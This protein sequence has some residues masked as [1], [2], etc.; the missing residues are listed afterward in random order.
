MIMQIA[1]ILLVLG[2]AYAWATR[3]FFNAL[4]HLVAVIVGGAVAFAVWEPLSLAIVNATE[5]SGWLWG[6]IHACAW[7]IGLIVPFAI[8]TIVVR[9]ILDKTIPANVQLV[10]AAD[11][12]GGGLCGLGAGIIC[13]GVLV[14]AIGATRFPAGFLGYKP[15]WYN[16]D[17]G[18]GL[19]SLKLTGGLWVPADKLTAAFYSSLSINAFGADESLATW[20]P[21]L[22]AAVYANRISSEDF[23]PVT[24][25]KRED[26]RLNGRYTVGDPAGG[27]PVEQ[28]LRFELQGQM[29]PMPYADT[30]GE[31]VGTGRLEGFI[32][33]FEAG[34]KDPG[35]RGA[36]QVVFSNGQA[37]LV[38]ERSDGS[39]FNV[40]P[41]AM[42]SQASSGDAVYGRWRFDAD[43]VVLASVGGASSVQLGLEFVVP[44]GAEPIGL[45]VKNARID[46][47]DG[48][49]EPVVYADIGSRNA[50]VRDGAI[51]RGDEPAPEFDDSRAIVIDPTTNS[52]V[53]PTNSLTGRLSMHVSM[54]RRNF[55]L[56]ED[57]RIQTGTGVYR[58][59]ADFNAPNDRN[60]KTDKFGVGRGQVLVQ[61]D[62]SDGS[63][64]SIIGPVARLEDADAP[65]RLI[66]TAGIAYDAVGYIYQESGEVTIRYTPED[67]L[68]GSGDIATPLSSTRT[69]QQLA[70][71]F[72][73]SFGVEIDR[74]AIGDTVILDF[75]PVLTLDRRQD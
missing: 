34:A 16:D 6:T 21:D 40:F 68:D 53:Q 15:I 73:C 23:T 56:D 24:S 47:R 10:T 19:G 44:Q 28:L 55:S 69:D 11:Y 61:I 54:A 37:R 36:G 18:A 3:G 14:I 48:G 5:S 66:D 51:L 1:V 33:T 20:Y 7:S 30:R 35:E 58:F 17:R 13:T 57:N 31:R 72:V 29:V 9:V 50:L 63:P 46:L 49:P 41:V 27:T 26:V 38:C 39:T 67:P 22:H 64:A 12:A 62:V 74:L 75:D 45:M 8:A 59:P 70:L 42:I 43:E 71:I 4:L 65:I 2:I 52:I 60:L 32:L 25:I